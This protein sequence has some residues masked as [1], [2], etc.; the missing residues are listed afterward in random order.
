MKINNHSDRLFL[1][2]YF[3]RCSNDVSVISL[4]MLRCS[5]WVILSNLLMKGYIKKHGKIEELTRCSFNDEFYVLDLEYIKKYYSRL[6][7]PPTSLR[8]KDS[9]RH[10]RH[11]IVSWPSGF[12]D[13]Y[14]SEVIEVF[15]TLDT[16]EKIVSCSIPINITDMEGTNM[17]I[18]A[19]S[20][21]DLDTQSLWQLSEDMI[22]MALD[23]V[24]Y[25]PT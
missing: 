3:P 1:D 11:I 4:G 16:S 12:I 20:I 13:R 21:G 18:Q 23:L 14:Q 15:A 10:I 9:N 25:F 5:V 24:E 8:I 19:I 17:N 2:T 6:P 22:Y 7:P